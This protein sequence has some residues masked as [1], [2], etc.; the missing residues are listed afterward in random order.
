M[1]KNEK[2]LIKQKLGVILLEPDSAIGS[3]PIDVLGNE[4]WQKRLT[5]AFAGKPKT[6]NQIFEICVA[7]TDLPHTSITVHEVLKDLMED[8]V[9]VVDSIEEG[10]NYDSF[11]IISGSTSFRDSFWAEILG[12]SVKSLNRYKK[13]GKTFK[14][15]QSEKILE[16]AEVSSLGKTVFNNDEDFQLWLNTPNFALGNKKPIELIKTSYGKEMVVAELTN[17]DQGIFI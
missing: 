6:I 3:V 10:L 17:I 11:K 12:L 5:E 8:R 14:P 9:S 7:A 16:V 13:L 1:T 15:I 2:E 4:Y